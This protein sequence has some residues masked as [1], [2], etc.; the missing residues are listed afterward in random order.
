MKHIKSYDEYKR[1]LTKEI[2]KNDKKELTKK[3]ISTFIKNYFLDIDY[4]FSAEE[5]RKDIRYIV[6]RIKYPQ[7]NNVAR[8]ESDKFSAND[9]STTT[10]KT[11]TD[12]NQ[13]LEILKNYISE[14][15][16]AAQNKDRIIQFINEYRLDVD[17]DIDEYQVSEDIRSIKRENAYKKHAKYMKD[18]FSRNTIIVKNESVVNNPDKKD[19]Q[20]TVSENIEKNV[21]ISEN[22]VLDA[23]DKKISDIL[24]QVLERYP[25]T[26][27]DNKIMNNMLSDLIVDDKM[28]LNI[29]RLLIDCGILKDIRESEELSVSL[30]YRYVKKMLSLVV[31]V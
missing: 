5:I 30:K 22:I 21:L 8:N 19:A 18:V 1:L 7:Y 28:K 12:Y 25:I 11:V 26:I 24:Y 6:Y 14:N 20:N 9:Y 23:D 2:L 15:E 29:L 4:G 3:Q 17:W 31:N 16:D 10:E 13:Y 27:T